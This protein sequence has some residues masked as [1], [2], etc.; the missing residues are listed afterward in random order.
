M[1]Q[2]LRL[3]EF[4]HRVLQGGSAGTRSVTKIGTMEFELVEPILNHVFVESLF[5]ID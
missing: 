3:A 1:A 2:V 4:G 5:V